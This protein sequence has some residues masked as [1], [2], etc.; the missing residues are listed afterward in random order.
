MSNEAF[1][2]T[3][4]VLIKAVTSALSGTGTPPNVVWTA[5]SQGNTS[6][7]SVWLYQVAVDE[8]SRNAPAPQGDYQTPTRTKAAAPPLGI[9]LYYLITPYFEQ[10]ETEQQALA[11]VM[12]YFYENPVLAV[13]QPDVGVNDQVRVTPLP[14]SLADRAT[15]WQALT[16]PF[17]LSMSYIVRTVRLINPNLVPVAPVNRIVTG[18]PPNAS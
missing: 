15:L 14:D 1:S 5:P 8:F 7:V 10:T 13:Y 18:L 12:L 17:K 9:N 4:S 16:Q 2:Q 11:Q 3:S 6:Q